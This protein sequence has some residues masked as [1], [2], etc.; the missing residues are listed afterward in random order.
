MFDYSYK[1]LRKRK[2]IL[3]GSFSVGKTSL[4]NRFIHNS[5]NHNYHTTIGVNIQTK[6]VEHRDYKYSLVIWDIA[7]GKV[8]YNVP[9]SYL[10]KSA[11]ALYVYDVSQPSTFLNLEEEI[12]VLSPKINYSPIIVVGNKT[13]LLSEQELVEHK[14]LMKHKTHIYTSAKEGDNVEKAFIQLVNA[15][16]EIET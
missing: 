8:K 7:G 5:F 12:K 9:Y 6:L 11:G 16:V 10:L 1:T 14:A 15:I 2:I 13:D 4:K 3:L